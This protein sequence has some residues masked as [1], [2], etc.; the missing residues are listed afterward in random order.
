[1]DENLAPNGCADLTAH[2]AKSSQQVFDER[3]ERRGREEGWLTL[4]CQHFCPAQFSDT[5]CLSLPRVRGKDAGTGM[6]GKRDPHVISRKSLV[7]YEWCVVTFP[8]GDVN[9]WIHPRKGNQ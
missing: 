3:E 7:F 1:M 5:L 8:L 4:V 6:K 9:K 2:G